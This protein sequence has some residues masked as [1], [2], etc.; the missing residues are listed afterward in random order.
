MIVYNLSMKINTDIE[1]EWV[2]WQK[3]EHILR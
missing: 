1:D 3:K 2:Q